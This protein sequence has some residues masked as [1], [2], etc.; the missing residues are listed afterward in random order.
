MADIQL[1]SELVEKLIDLVNI[2]YPDW[3]GF[4]DP[5]YIQDELSYKESAV[6]AAQLWLKKEELQELLSN[7][8]FEEFKD[9]IEKVGRSGKNLLYMAVPTAGDLN[10]LYEESHDS[11][12]FCQ[13]FF[14]LLYG[15]RTSAERLDKFSKYLESHDLPNKWTFPTYFMYLLDPK[16]EMFVKPT[17]K[18]WFLKLCGADRSLPSKPNGRDYQN[19]LDLS[20]QLMDELRQFNPTNF[21][22]IQSFLWVA[23][24]AENTSIITPEKVKEFKILFNE[25][26]SAYLDTDKGV[27]HI[28]YLHEGRKKAIENIKSINQ[29][30][31]N[32]EDITDMVLLRL[33]PYSDSENNRQKGAWINVASAIQGNLKTWFENKGWTN[34]ENWPKV[35]IAILNFVNSCIENP[36][37]IENACVKFTE[38]PYTT[39]FQTGMM[40]PILNALK[41]DEFMI[42]NNKS[43]VVLNY[44]TE[45]DYKQPLVNYPEINTTG[46]ELVSSLKSIFDEAE[47]F[48]LKHLDFFDIFSHWLVAEKRFFSPKT[49]GKNLTNL[50]GNVDNALLAFKFMQTATSYLGIE[51]ADDPLIAFTFFKSG[52]QT[53]LHMSYGKR[54]AIGFHGTGGEISEVLIS[55]IKDSVDIP[56]I[57]SEDFAH[58]KGEKVVTWY[59][60]DFDDVERHQDALLEAFQETMEYFHSLFSTWSASPYK[61]FNDKKLAEAVLDE[62][63]RDQVFHYDLTLRSSGEENTTRYW[64]VAPGVGA[65]NWETWKKENIIAIGWDQVGDL[66]GKSKEEIDKVYDETMKSYPDWGAG[67]K[68]QLTRFMEI[69]IGDQIIANKGKSEILGCGTVTGDYYFIPGMDHGHRI[70]VQWDSFERKSINEGGWIMTILELSK[71]KFDQLLSLEPKEGLFKQKTFDLLVGLHENPSADF[72]SKNKDALKEYVEGPFQDLMRSV[73]N[74]LNPEIVDFMETEKGVFSRFLKN[75]YGRGGAWDYYWGRF[76]PKG[77]NKSDGPQLILSINREVMFAGFILGDYS[78]DVKKLFAENIITNKKRISEL[79]GDIFSKDIITIGNSYLF[80]GSVQEEKPNTPS[81][82]E[83]LLADPKIAEYDLTKVFLKEDLL[84]LS[85]NEL[86]DE[87]AEIYNQ[88]YPFV[89]LASRINPIPGIEKYLD[90]SSPQIEQPPYSLEKCSEETGFKLTE[91][92]KYVRAIDRKKQAIFYGPPG[93]GKTYL[94]ERIAKHLVGGGSGFIE[95]IQFHPE[96]AYEDFIQGIRPQEND[97]G[98]LRYPLVPGRFHEFC[99]KASQTEDICVLIIDEI[100]RA[101]LSRVFGELMY[102]LEYR[103]KAINLAAGERFMIPSNVRIIGTMNTADRS[104]ALVDHALRRRFAFLSLYPDYDLLRKYHQ[105]VESGFNPENLIKVLEKLNKQ[106]GDRHYFIGPSYFLREDIRDHLKDIWQMEIEPYLEEFFFDQPDNYKKFAWE[107]IQ[108]EIGQ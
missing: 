61:K 43:R 71:D 96:V 50:F 11:Q 85:L 74:K 13:A 57:E 72:Y 25:F 100:N 33:L 62:S 98:E 44:F 79:L 37:N 28:R 81:T 36:E 52:L 91:L 9:R 58:S 5:R 49:L 56:F 53:K 6:D 10:V 15:D 87:I 88:L 94:A 1:T 84:I 23:K 80:S 12:S 54:L 59:R 68:T 104:I 48:E 101:N 66:S 107:T 18:S 67:G 51:R 19:I 63:V 108:A 90:I 22:D 42:V 29:S 14:D 27:D 75:D 82:I 93:T 60:I 106:I 92:S 8:Q 31:G 103:D 39:G 16:S 7:H 32:G 105:K 26:I 34:P 89:I 3:E 97:N 17:T 102:L 4:S 47:K 83:A 2:K 24:Q 73:V 95:L 55:L 41:P 21:I 69:Q 78:S 35:S 38:L 40:T 30:Y 46:K 65:W 64:K 70:P 86:S 99:E 20:N 45:S 77:I 76:Y